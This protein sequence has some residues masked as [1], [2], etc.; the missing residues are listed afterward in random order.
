[1]DLKLWIPGRA[2]GAHTVPSRLHPGQPITCAWA[3][4][5]RAADRRIRI[6]TPHERPSFPGELVVFIFCGAEH[7]T[8]FLQRSK[9]RAFRART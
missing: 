6:E 1:M 8:Y 2:A 7:R 4:C 9:N 3:D 5:T